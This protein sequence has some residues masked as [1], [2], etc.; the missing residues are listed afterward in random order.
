MHFTIKETAKETGFSEHTLRY[1]EKIG[2]IT[3]VKRSESG[4]R[5][6]TQGDIN[7]ILFL[8]RLKTTGMSLKFIKKYADMKH[9]GETTF[10]NRK[11]LL[12]KHK[13]KV[14]NDINFLKE[15]LK[16]IQ[17]QWNQWVSENIDLS[18]DSSDNY[19]E[20]Y[21]YKRDIEYL[22]NKYK[23]RVFGNPFNGVAISIAPIKDKYI[24]GEM[25]EIDVLFKNVS[26]K[27]RELYKFRIVSQ[28]TKKKTQKKIHDLE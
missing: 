7:W 21:A 26:Q 9:A 28:T 8:K 18:Q 16:A 20:S 23:D 22:N 2:L 25:I 11:E 15:N 19:Y 3:D 17:Q 5:I 14:M 24:L 12:E 1:Y 27:E 4:R 13:E 6:F 10:K